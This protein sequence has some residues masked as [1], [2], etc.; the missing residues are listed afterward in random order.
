MRLN[1]LRNLEVVSGVMAE[2][3]AG[4]TRRLG[5]GVHPESLLAWSAQP[6]MRSRLMTAAAVEPVTDLEGELARYQR[7][8]PEG[9]QSAPPTRAEGDALLGSLQRFAAAWSGAA[10]ALAK[11]TLPSQIELLFRSAA[12]LCTAEDL[13]RSEDLFTV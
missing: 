8:V 3:G 7:E 5:R 1:S 12:N 2:P 13:L 6:L 4:V 9:T 10:P 11:G